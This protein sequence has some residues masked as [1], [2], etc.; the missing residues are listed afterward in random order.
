MNHTFKLLLGYYL[1]YADLGR[2]YYVA[3]AWK[4]TPRGR[5]AQ[6]AYDI[7]RLEGWV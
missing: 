5:A 1:D 3:T 7:R 4:D 2:V 6:A